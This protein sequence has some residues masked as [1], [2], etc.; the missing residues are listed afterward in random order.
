L[1]AAAVVVAGAGLHGPLQL[2][3]AAVATGQWWRLVT[4]HWTH[5]SLDHAVWD[6][7]VFAGLGI[8]CELRSRWRFVACVGTSALVI[9]LGV[10]LWMPRMPMYRGLSGIDSALFGLLAML[11]L[12]ESVQRQSWPWIAV[13]C[14]ALFGFIFK[15]THELTTGATIFVDNSAGGFVPVPLAHLL[16]AAVGVVVGLIPKIGSR[17]APQRL[18]CESPWRIRSAAS[19]SSCTDISRMSCITVRTRTAKPGSSKQPRRRTCR[20][21]T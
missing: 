2:D 21:S 6:V 20:S 3:R 8:A 1:T 16:G 17:I 18:R 14:V 12:R 13:V 4:C 5:W 19:R 7:L 15:S 9:A 10:L 11:I